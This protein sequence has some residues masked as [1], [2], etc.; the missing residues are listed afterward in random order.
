MRD[1]RTSL[2]QALPFDFIKMYAV[3][4]YGALAHQSVVIVNIQI[5]G[6]IRKKFV[7]PGDFVGVFRDVRLHVRLWKLTP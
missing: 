3:A 4:K 7:Y 1:G 6:A 2:M 5:V